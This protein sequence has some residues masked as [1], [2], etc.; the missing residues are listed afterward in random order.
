MPA[1]ANDTN[2]ST[3]IAANET[4]ETVETVV[5]TETQ[6]NETLA[7][8]TEATETPE[9]AKAETPT[10][11]K[12]RT[13]PVVKIRPLNDEVT[14]DQSNLIEF[15]FSN[16][17]INDATLTAEAYI[18]VPSGIHIYAEGFSW[19]AGAGTLHG[20][21]EVKPGNS[22]VVH[23]EVI[24]AKEGEYYIHASVMY[25]PNENKD[26]YRQLSLTHPFKV[27]KAFEKEPSSAQQITTPIPPKIDLTW[28][29]L[30]A[31]VL[32]G[33]AIIFAVRR[34]PPTIKIEER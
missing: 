22:R 8:V 17:A 20:H 3:E 16:P 32:G 7:E 4:I 14:V 31:V 10:A 12:F 13:P 25:Y 33:I 34:R 27:I 24:G 6:T 29:V 23:A 2:V 21:F 26:D 30:I 5:A 9:V 28:I 19:D 11:G 1:M 15:Y 18:S